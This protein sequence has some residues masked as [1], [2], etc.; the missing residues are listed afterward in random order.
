MFAVLMITLLLTVSLLDPIWI[1]SKTRC[2]LSSKESEIVENITISQGFNDQMI[3]KFVQQKIDE[4]MKALS[5]DAPWY[6]PTKTWI[7][8]V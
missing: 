7:Y 3:E 2:N 1:H 4:R 6:S 5:L 8:D